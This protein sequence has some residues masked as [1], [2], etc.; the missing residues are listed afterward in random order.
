MQLPD[1][2]SLAVESSRVPSEIISGD[3]AS[4]QDQQ[5][6]HWGQ[7]TDGTATI[8]NRLHF[9]PPREEGTEAVPISS[10]SEPLRLGDLDPLA[11]GMQFVLILESPCINHLYPSSDAATHEP[12][13][14]ALTVSGQL[15]PTYPKA[16]FESPEKAARETFR[17][18]VP[19]GSLRSLLAL[20]SDLCPESEITPVQAWN[21]I[22]CQPLF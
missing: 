17:R 12:N 4:E 20:S 21:K 6:Q 10:H 19:E 3:W 16:V 9:T 13:G 11:I 22:R 5:Q 2:I 8:A 7:L 18:E 1:E 15:A 14:H